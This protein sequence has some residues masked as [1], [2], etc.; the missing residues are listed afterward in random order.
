MSENEFNFAHMP[1]MGI[2][3]KEIYFAHHVGSSK[4]NFVQSINPLEFKTIEVDQTT[5]N[6]PLSIVKYAGLNFMKAA[7]SLLMSHA[8]FLKNSHVRNLG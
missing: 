6:H 4:E 7:K 5:N 1:Y 8:A 3:S 2:R